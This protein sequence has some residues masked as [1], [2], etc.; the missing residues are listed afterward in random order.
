MHYLARSGTRKKEETPE[1]CQAKGPRHAPVVRGFL[2]RDP[3]VTNENGVL[4]LCASD[5]ID[6]LVV[7]CKGRQA[8]G[9]MEE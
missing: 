2:L 6:L 4:V 8:H 5:S 9:S 3:S 7:E 1:A